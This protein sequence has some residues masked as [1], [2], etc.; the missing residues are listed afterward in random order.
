MREFN[1]FFIGNMHMY[2]TPCGNELFFKL[3]NLY[4]HNEG[5]KDIGIYMNHNMIHIDMY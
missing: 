3:L 2:I 5:T 4:N 1:S